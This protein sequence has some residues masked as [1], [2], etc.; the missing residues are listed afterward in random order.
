VNVHTEKK[1]KRKR[2]GGIISIVT[3][4]EDKIYRIS[5]FKRR[6]LGDNTSVP[7][8]YKYGRVNDIMS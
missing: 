2:K 4:P 6:R 3:E 5:F 1:I 7:F 8:A